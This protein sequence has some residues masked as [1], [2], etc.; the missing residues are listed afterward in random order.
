MK[1]FQTKLLH[2]YLLLGLSATSAYGQ[3]QVPN[4][5]VTDLN[6]QPH[7]LYDYLDSNKFVVLDFF[8]TNCSFC[9]YYAPHMQQSYE[10]FG[11]NNGNTI[12]L[13]IDYSDSA[14]QVLNFV[15][16]YGTEYPVA[17]GLEGGGDSIVA[18]YNISSFPSVL[19]INPQR[20]LMK[21]VTSPT[22]DFVDTVLS[23]AGCV[24]QPCNMGLGRIDISSVK[25]MPV[26][27]KPNEIV[28][29]QMPDYLQEAWM[30]V[31]R[32]DGAIIE[33]MSISGKTGSFIAPPNIG[34]YILRISADDFLSTTK[35]LVE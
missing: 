16:T 24:I 13:G 30:E 20:Y 12:F 7:T 8:F 14:H 15:Q 5:T 11:C 1:P 17:S 10:D 26:P 22:T 23:L 32:L 18:A 35:L 31:I 19:L 34:I 2:L 33:Q 3:T 6:G 4:F 28:T 9:Q 29:I 21:V 25:L 27:A